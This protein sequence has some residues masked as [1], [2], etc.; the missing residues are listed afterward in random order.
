MSEHKHNILI[1]KNLKG[2]YLQYYDE[3]WNSYLF[4]NNKTQATPNNQNEKDF[5]EN[6]L[7]IDRETISINLKKDVIHTK[8]S[9]SAKKDK[10]YHHFFYEVILSKE[11][12]LIAEKTFTINDIKYRWFSLEELE[13]DARIQE[14]NSDIVGMVKELEGE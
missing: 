10:L 2:E 9:E 3:R 4:L 8:Y 6:K 1:I 14:V 5:L 7:F 13:S 12:P 11:L